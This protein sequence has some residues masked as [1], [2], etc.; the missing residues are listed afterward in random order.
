MENLASKMREYLPEDLLAF[1]HIAAGVAVAGGQSLYL[2]G[3]AVRDILLGHRPRLDFDLVLEGNAPTLARQLA[4][5]SGDKVLVYRRFGT[6]KFQRGELSIDLV[7]ARSETYSR[8]GALPE[9]KPGTI[10][11][12]LLRRDFSINAIAIDLNP[13]SFGQLFDP[14][15]GRSDLE[16][17]LIRILHE[18]SFIDDATRILRA[19]RYEQRLGFKLEQNTE[20][21][22]RQNTLMLNTISGDRIRHE[23][24]LMLKEECPEKV[25]E[26]AEKLGVLQA[27]HPSLQGNGW[28]RQ[29]FQEARQKAM[30]DP[31]FCLLLLVYPL[32]EEDSECLLTRL[33]I[34]GELGRKMRQVLK[35]KR[36]LP[37]LNDPALLPSDAYRLLKRYPP[38]VIAACALAQ[39][40]STSRSHLELYLSHL[41]YVKTSLDGEDLKKMGLLPGPRLGRVL[42]ELREAKLNGKVST[43]EDEEALVGQWLKQNRGGQIEGAV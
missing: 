7:T 35:L 11:D 32:A 29:K 23:L 17:G 28:L 6:A 16:R 3:G 25:L 39:D 18:E 37:S 20:R 42:E 14:H 34:T 22:L 26:R 27:L 33:N 15:G 30:L 13:A 41:R 4:K 21:L 24:E 8:P 12:D 38:E 19:L 2:V 40:D 9:V 43:R 36:D 5:A 31:A 1:L 10:R